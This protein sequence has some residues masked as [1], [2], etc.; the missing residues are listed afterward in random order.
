MTFY[1][2]RHCPVGKCTYLWARAPV[3]DQNTTRQQIAIQSLIT[4]S[5]WHCSRTDKYMWSDSRYYIACSPGFTAHSALRNHCWTAV[6]SCKANAANITDSFTTKVYVWCV[7]RRHDHH[8]NPCSP[9]QL[10]CTSNCIVYTTKTSV[11][12]QF[13]LD[14]ISS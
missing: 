7:V 8:K 9:K 1:Y 13:M 4:A 3:H 10:V 2:S 5:N 14:S 12:N 6:S 11:F